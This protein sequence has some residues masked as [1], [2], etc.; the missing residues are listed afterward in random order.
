MR[1][2]SAGRTARCSLLSLV[3]RPWRRWI[4]YGRLRRADRR[5]YSANPS[6]GKPGDLSR[7]QSETKAPCSVGVPAGL[8]FFLAQGR[9][10]KTI[11][12]PRHPCRTD[13]KDL[14]LPIRCRT[15]PESLS[16]YVAEQPSTFKERQRRETAAD[17]IEIRNERPPHYE[18]KDNCHAGNM[19]AD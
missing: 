8:A 1:Y 5:G 4:R 14:H 7:L 18:G 10:R 6:Y 17:Y 11:N 12:K 3:I 13:P 9:K 2:D 15:P 19:Y 16:L